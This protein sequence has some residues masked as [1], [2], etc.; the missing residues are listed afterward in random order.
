MILSKETMIQRWKTLDEA[1]RFAVIAFLVIRIF[2]FLW[3]W[4]I[5]TIQPLAVQNID[6]SDEPLLT[7]FNLGNSQSYIYS[8]EINGELLTFR[9][10]SP[11]T[12][13]D[14]QSGS[15]WDISTGTAF[16]G[17]FKEFTLL[18]ARTVPSEIFPYHHIKCFK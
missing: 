3:S 1:W 18:R 10:E 15:L 6:L 16:E 5:L 12:V 8:R 4:I 11:N 13:I 14:L 2:Y 9:A 17:P 7:I